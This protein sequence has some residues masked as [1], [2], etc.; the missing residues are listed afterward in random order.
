MAG[1]TIC[2]SDAYVFLALL[3]LTLIFALFELEGDEFIIPAII[4]IVGGILTFRNKR[5][6]DDSALKKFNELFGNI[7]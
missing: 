1:E 6:Q 3:V 2:R 7:K 4:L 5:H